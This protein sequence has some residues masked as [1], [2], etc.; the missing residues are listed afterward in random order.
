M[1]ITKR[2]MTLAVTG[3]MFVT[4]CGGSGATTAPSVAAPAPGRGHRPGAPGFRRNRILSC[5]QHH[6]RRLDGA[7][8]ARRRRPEAVPRQTAPAPRSR[9]RAAAPEPG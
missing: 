4:A 2:V 7:P 5:R 1:Q 6:G 3:L 8:A 9:S